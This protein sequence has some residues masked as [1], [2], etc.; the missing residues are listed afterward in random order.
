[1]EVPESSSD[2]GS[3]AARDAVAAIVERADEREKAK[4]EAEAEQVERGPAKP[5]LARPAVAVTLMVVFVAILAVDVYMRTRPP[6]PP[7][8][9]ELES[10]ARIET[11]IAA[12]RIEAFNEEHGRYPESLAEAGIQL[13]GVEYSRT[14]QG[15]TLKSRPEAYQN[16]EAPPVQSPPQVQHQAGED[17][18]ALV[19]AIPGVGGGS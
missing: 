1:M 10:A 19:R 14:A 9:V 5:F 16:P 15:Y 4:A 17:V 2:L 18:E 12:L 6:A 8:S 13:V 11:G 3:E 7:T